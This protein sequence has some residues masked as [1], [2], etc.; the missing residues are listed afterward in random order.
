[1]QLNQK[2]FAVIFSFGYIYCVFAIFAE[3]AFRSSFALLTAAPPDRPD[4]AGLLES[5]K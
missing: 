5:R 4:R 3:L 1:M 2:Y